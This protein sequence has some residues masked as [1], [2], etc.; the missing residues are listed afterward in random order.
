MDSIQS[1]SES[2]AGVPPPVL[3]SSGAVQ[4]G[5]ASTSLCHRLEHG[6]EHAVLRAA[7]N[8]E[9]SRLVF[10]CY[11]ERYLTPADA[12]HFTVQHQQGAE[13]RID[14]L[15]GAHS[16]LY[17]ARLKDDLLIVAHI[18][19]RVVPLASATELLNLMRPLLE[20][21]FPKI[22]VDEARWHHLLSV[23]DQAVRN[24]AEAIADKMALDALIEPYGS[25]VAYASGLSP[26]DTFAFFCRYA[27]Y[28]G[29]YDMPFS[30]M[31][32]PLSTEAA[33]RYA[34]EFGNDVPI[35][36]VAVH[37]RHV[38]IEGASEPQSL[39]DLLSQEYPEAGRNWRAALAERGLD[40]DEFVALPVHPLALD[41]YR[42][43]LAELI[44]AGEVLLETGV[45]IAGKAALSYRTILPVGEDAQI[46]IKLPVP[47]QLTG[48][49]RYIDVEELRAAPRLSRRL[50]RLLADDG[51]AVADLRL[52]RELMSACVVPN[53]GR[54]QVS[55]DT[56]FLSCL[57]RETQGR[58]LPH[59][60]MTMPLAALF[61]ASYVSGKPMLV[62]M[63]EKAGVASQEQAVSYFMRYMRMVL[64]SVLRLY[65]R[66]GVM[67][68]AHQQN[69]GVTFDVAGNVDLL[70]Y[71]DVACAVFFYRPAYLAA[72]HPGTDLQGLSHPY[73]SD[74]AQY[75]CLQLVHTLL[76][77]NL[78]PV[79]DVV[80]EYFELPKAT[81]LRH[82]YAS[83]AAML[84]EERISRRQG[85]PE[86]A[87]VFAK[88]HDEV[89]QRVLTSETF[90]TKRLLGRLFMQSQTQLWGEV[91]NRDPAFAA[92]KGS[93]VAIANPL[94][95]FH[96][97][98]RAAEAS[99]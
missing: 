83:I 71:H 35:G 56:P 27:A 94:H 23:S 98:A 5:G 53:C 24:E 90:N 41:L 52:D 46:A 26:N 49:V 36:L 7:I 97:E 45:S 92:V 40:P 58:N 21:A 84:E 79:I 6:S 73:A 96:V 42:D 60:S 67:I 48:Y 19:G 65:L 15:D 10:V 32:L 70:N 54:E 82:V 47:L 11:K 12:W 4:G 1:G 66:H 18:H 3:S 29:H 61:S 62:E 16:L 43:N 8:N 85:R 57:L 25:V 51:D 38:V 37:A 59:G 63:M 81:L 68:E 17:D 9:L 44:E 77:V 75:S 69:L 76:V 93:S 39:L 31:R 55:F 22:E 95:V 20:R 91:P 64:G 89:E 30:K 78:L 34:P 86:V 33:R 80:A 50:A 14:S 28:F 72:G 13:I 99:K 87:S 88:L 74:D 2:G